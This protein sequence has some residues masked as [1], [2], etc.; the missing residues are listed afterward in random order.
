MEDQAAERRRALRHAAKGEKPQR[1]AKIGNPDVYYARREKSQGQAPPHWRDA[2][3]GREGMAKA[4][5]NLQSCFS[6]WASKIRACILVRA[7]IGDGFLCSAREEILMKKCQGRA[8]ISVRGGGCGFLQE[9]AFCA[10]GR[11]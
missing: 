6:P 8:C 2:G 3:E 5:E 11:V 7:G 1:R 10:Q 4:G 9:R